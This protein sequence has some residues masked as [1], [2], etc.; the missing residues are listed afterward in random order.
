MS[1]GR[2]PASQAGF[3]F[4]AM[5]IA[6]AVIGAGL[7]ATGEI[8][9]QSSQREKEQELLFVGN[10]F[11]QAIA[12][13]YERT[14]GAA[15]QYPEKLEQLLDD[16]RHLTVQRYLRKIYVDPMTGTPEWGLVF[17]KPGGRIMGV[18]SLSKDAPIKMSG[19]R[20]RDRHLEGATQ[21]LE[22]RF[23]Y[24][25]PQATGSPASTPTKPV[26]TPAVPSGRPLPE[27]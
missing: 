1:S 12:L 22:W 2:S 9:S 5:L 15:K 7:A 17:D 19:F 11:R 24:E 4:V 16:K 23:V 10:Q 6:I 14:P 26:T 27:K 20:A 21:Y 8:W 13:Y 25:P 3:T 18:Y